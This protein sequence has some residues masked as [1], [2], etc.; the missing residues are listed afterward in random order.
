MMFGMREVFSYFE[1]DECGCLQLDPRPSDMRRYYPGE[2][3]ALT[4]REEPTPPPNGRL[5]RWLF[6]KRNEAQ[7]FG[8]NMVWSWIAGRRP[9]PDLKPLP[10]YLRVSAVKGLRTRIM[11]VGCGSGALLREL[12]TAGFRDLLGVDPYLKESLRLGDNLRI[13]ATT[14]DAIEERCFDLIMFH[15]SLEHMPRQVQTLRRAAE[16]LADGGICLIRVPV[17]SSEAWKQ[18]GVDWVELDAPRHFFV[19][20]H[21]SIAITARKAGMQVVRTEFDTTGFAYWGSEM[22][23]KGLSLY[24]GAVRRMRDPEAVFSPSELAHFEERAQRANRLGTGGRA[25]YYLQRLESDQ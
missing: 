4:A 21:K 2:Y 24:D 8:G 20:T 7:L 5:R 23:R 18:Y 16:L 9:R 11:D 1:C 6:E 12:A 19:H 25:I 15:H 22:Y 13:V 14:L 3:A 10:E 17:A